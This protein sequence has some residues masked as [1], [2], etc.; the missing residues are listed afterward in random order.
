MKFQ[1]QQK[2]NLFRVRRRWLCFWM[3]IVYDFCGQY[4]EWF[5]PDYTS[6]VSLEKAKSFI[7]DNEY[8]IVK[9]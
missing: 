8:S 9:Y 5:W 7:E 6:W 3:Y 2:N 1:I 4:G